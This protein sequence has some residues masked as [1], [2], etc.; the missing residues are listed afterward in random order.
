MLKPLGDVYTRF[1]TP[2]KYEVLKNSIVSGGKGQDVSGIG[3]TLSVDKVPK[4]NSSLAQPMCCSEAAICMS[5]MHVHDF[6]RM[7][8]RIASSAFHHCTLT[9]L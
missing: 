3:V 6:L 8:R 4:M 2:T 7:C 9:M 1:I 5:C